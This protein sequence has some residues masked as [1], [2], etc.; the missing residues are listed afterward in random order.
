M[1]ASLSDAFG[2]PVCGFQY[3]HL[4]KV[5]VAARREDEPITPIFVDAVTGFVSKNTHAVPGDD[6]ARRQRIAVLGTCE[7]GH[8]FAIVF[9]QYKGSTYVETLSPEW[10]AVGGAK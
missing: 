4:D 6:S 3:T 5:L 8:E 10:R 9:T 2:C 7:S 1:Q